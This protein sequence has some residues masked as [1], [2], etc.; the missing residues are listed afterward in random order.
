[1]TEGPRNK[2]ERLAIAGAVAPSVR[3]GAASARERRVGRLDSD[4]NVVGYTTLA[5]VQRALLERDRIEFDV[6]AERPARLVCPECGGLMVAKR[7]GKERRRC[8]ACTHPRCLTCGKRA[9]SIK[10]QGTR[11]TYV[12]WSCTAKS[13]RASAKAP[14]YAT[15]SDCGAQKARSSGQRCRPCASAAMAAV[16]RH[17]CE[18]CSKPMKR[19]RAGRCLCL[20]CAHR[21]IAAMR[22]ATARP[23]ASCATCGAELGRGAMAPSAVKKRAG[24][25]PQCGACRRARVARQRKEAA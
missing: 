22:K 14:T 5:E 7:K 18:D 17:R 3:A 4:G 19:R 11:E 9:R 13:L 15:C 2:A 16:I 10:N 21:R 8:D 25:P 12:C 1:M 6:D 24:K 23:R 20:P